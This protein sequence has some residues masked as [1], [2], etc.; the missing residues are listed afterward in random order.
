[1]ALAVAVALG[2]VLT[3]VMVA[4][5]RRHSN[6]PAPPLP[7]RLP[8]VSIL[9]PLKGADA[10][11]AENLASFFRLDYPCYEV[12]LGADDP[13][14][15][16]AEVARRVVAAHPSV[17]SL[18]IV[19]GRRTGYN[20]KVNN[21]ANLARQ[22][23]YT[24]LWIADSNVRVT[25]DALHDLVAHLEQPGVGL[26][27]SPFRGTAETGLG[28]ACEALQLNT[29]VAGGVAAAHE[30][31]AGVCVV[32]K[33]MLL[34]SETLAALG[35]FAHLSRYLAEDQVCGEEVARR[36][37]GVV[38]ARR[39]LDNVLGPVSVS[40]F[41]ARHL[42]WARIRRRMNPAA[43]VGEILTNPVF[44]ALLGVLLLRDA[45]SLGIFAAA[46]FGKSMLDAV[47][48]RAVG[49]HRPLAVYP[50][51]TF[52]KDTLIGCAWIV[53]FFSTSVTWRGNRL[54]IGPRTWLI[55]VPSPSQRVVGVPGLVTRV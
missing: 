38:L 43:Y 47:V 33:S 16:A 50:F 28:G 26:V 49:V 17:P 44:I 36:R 27:S 46:V 15:P 2:L 32:G 8:A 12:L 52:F 6:T 10:G 29:F 24:V 22:A 25:P 39:R 42:R 51:L 31:N 13:E 40:R 45:A 55:P 30:L 7:E 11:L 9:K 34:R 54:R 5:Q 53:P 21:L 23:R 37:G 4:A 19:D 3:A 41:L 20:P 35:G 48:E 1:M 18:V 14:D